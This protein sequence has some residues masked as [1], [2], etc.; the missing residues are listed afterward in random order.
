MV[1]STIENMAKPI[2]FE[3]GASDDNIQ[4]ELLNGFCKGLNNSIP[5]RGNL[6]TQIFHI[7][8][9]LDDNAIKI[10]SEIHEFINIK[11]DK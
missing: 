1:K 4:S 5:D 3:I 7:V 2:G 8:D 6:S 9:K 11:I 10:L